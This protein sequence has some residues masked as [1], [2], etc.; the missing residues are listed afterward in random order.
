MSKTRRTLPLPSQYPPLPP[1]HAFTAH[2][3]ARHSVLFG[4]TNT[5]ASRQLTLQPP[6]GHVSFLGGISLSLLVHSI[7]NNTHSLRGTGICLLSF[8]LFVLCYPLLGPVGFCDGN[9][10]FGGTRHLPVWPGSLARRIP[11]FIAD[12]HDTLSVQSGVPRRTRS[13]DSWFLR[14]PAIH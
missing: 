6:K 9:A 3:A 8:F 2:E 4:I 5:P 11:R 1:N 13:R 12:I 10:P 7:S 14:F